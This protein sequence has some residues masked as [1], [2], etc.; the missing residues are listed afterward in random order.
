[1]SDNKL[2]YKCEEDKEG[3]FVIQQLDGQGNVL[4]DP[5]PHK[6]KEKDSAIKYLSMM[7]KDFDKSGH[8]VKTEDDFQFDVFIK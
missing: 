1:M 8:E 3:L 2:T 4:D 6:F 7:K 5:N